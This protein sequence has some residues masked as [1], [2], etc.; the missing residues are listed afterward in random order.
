MNIRHNWC[1]TNCFNFSGAKCSL[2]CNIGG[3]RPSAWLPKTYIVACYAH[4]FLMYECE[5]R[6][7]VRQ[8]ER[9]SVTCGYAL[10]LAKWGCVPLVLWSRLACRVLHYCSLHLS[11]ASAFRYICSQ[12]RHD[13]SFFLLPL[14]VAA[15]F[16]YRSIYKQNAARP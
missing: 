8:P 4:L 10:P 11:G 9:T 5:N 2:R 16:I 15:L 13:C 7:F 6:M 1:E 3:T 12:C 14:M